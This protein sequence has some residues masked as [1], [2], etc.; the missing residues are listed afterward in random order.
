MQE[1]LTV[2]LDNLI[3]Q[4]PI[5]AIEKMALVLVRLWLTL[6]MFFSCKKTTTGKLELMNDQKAFLHP[7]MHS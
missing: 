1:N 6:K 5:P 7:F 3:S 4:N 2:F